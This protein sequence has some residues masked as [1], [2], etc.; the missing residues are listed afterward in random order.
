MNIGL[1]EAVNSDSRKVKAVGFISGV[2]V[3][4]SRPQ[5]VLLV[6]CGMPSLQCWKFPLALISSFLLSCVELN[7]VVVLNAEEEQK[8]TQLTKLGHFYRA[9]KELFCFSLRRNHCAST[10]GNFSCE[11]EVA[12]ISSVDTKSL[13]ALFPLLSGEL[14]KSRPRAPY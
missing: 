11:F 8:L 4:T 12:H 14:H 1:P 9:R 13:L 3:L 2:H 7:E 10:T 6:D 5:I